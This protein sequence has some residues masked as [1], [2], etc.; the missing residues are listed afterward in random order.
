MKREETAVYEYIKAN[1]DLFDQV[2]SA[3]QHPKRMYD[4]EYTIL[5]YK[6]ILTD[7]CDYMEGYL[8]YNANRDR[9]YAS[10]LLAT[11][12]KFYDATFESKKYR[13]TMGLPDMP[14][15]QY[16]FL[17]Q[18]KKLQDIMVKVNDVED[19]LHA[20]LLLTNNQY[21]KLSRVFSDDMK[22]WLWLSSSD[23]LHPTSIDSDLRN[24]FHDKNTP[25]MHPKKDG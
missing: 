3:N 1:K 2:Q 17:V 23:T 7:I 13:M 9:K 16:D 25:V 14:D 11:T 6:S 24:K 12:A 22:I 10:R 18:S 21:R 8:E 4:V 15:I 20:M 5:N 19:E